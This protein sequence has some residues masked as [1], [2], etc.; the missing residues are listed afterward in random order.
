MSRP[1]KSKWYPTPD[2]GHYILYRGRRYQGWHSQVWYLLGVCET[3]DPRAQ[4][5]FDEFAPHMAPPMK[6]IA[7]A[8]LR[9]DRRNKTAA[10]CL[11]AG[12]ARRKSREE[13]EQR[14]SLYT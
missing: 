14:R 5:L 2:Q 7:E 4:E 11:S 10:H 8:I 3:G 1:D 9:G 12:A 13:R 6:R